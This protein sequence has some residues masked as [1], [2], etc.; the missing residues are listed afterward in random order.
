MAEVTDL[1]TRLRL[2]WRS[3]G[4]RILQ[5]HPSDVAIAE[6]VVGCRL[7]EDYVSFLCEVGLPECDDSEGFRFWRPNELRHVQS[8]LRDAGYASDAIH[9]AIVFA[10]CMQESWWFALWLSGPNLGLVSL[11]LG[12]SSG[13]DPQPPMGTFQ[14]F[15]Q[16]YLNDEAILYPPTKG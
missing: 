3:Q 2:H 7:P 9:P 13:Q 16:S 4:L 8:V 11:A 15:L 5:Q 14:N 12:T 10:D 1:A 6:S